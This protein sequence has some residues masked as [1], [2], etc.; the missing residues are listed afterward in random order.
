M[1]EDVHPLRDLS[2]TPLLLGRTPFLQLVGVAEL[3]PQFGIDQPAGF[4]AGNVVI[5]DVE[6]SH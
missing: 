4:I 5:V 2:L 3:V 1:F 6:F